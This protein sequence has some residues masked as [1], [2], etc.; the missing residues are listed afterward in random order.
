VCVIIVVEEEKT[1]VTDF[2][3]KNFNHLFKITCIKKLKF[4]VNQNKI[5]LYNLINKYL[6]THGGGQ[7]VNA[8]AGEAP[9]DTAADEIF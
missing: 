9:T 6:N 8:A 5:C 3:K 4:Y 2:F 1:I 7:V